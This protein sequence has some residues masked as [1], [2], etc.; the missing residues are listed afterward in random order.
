M[1]NIMRNRRI[2]IH[3][4]FSPLSILGSSSFRGCRRSPCHI[5]CPCC[6]CTS[7]MQGVV[8]TATAAAPPA[9]G[10]LAAPWPPASQAAGRGQGPHFLAFAFWLQAHPPRPTLTA[11]ALQPAAL[12]PPCKFQKPSARVHSFGRSL[13]RKHEILQASISRKPKVSFVPS[14]QK[15]CCF[16]PI[17]CGFTCSISLVILQAKLG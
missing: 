2:R 7:V 10:P 5:R 11:P 13:T 16:S 3:F 8:R 14:R 15:P 4:S 1:Q 17:P 9:S 12:Q 6:C